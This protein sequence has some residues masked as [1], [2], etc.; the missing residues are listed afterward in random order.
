MAR[1]STSGLSLKDARDSTSR[2]RPTLKMICWNVR[3]K[4]RTSRPDSWNIMRLESSSG[5]PESTVVFDVMSGS[6]ATA[7]AAFAGSGRVRIR[8]YGCDGRVGEYGLHVARQDVH[9][10]FTRIRCSEL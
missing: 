6:E 9:L 8:L 5:Q 1:C 7:E 3:K 10:P 4:R 2:Q